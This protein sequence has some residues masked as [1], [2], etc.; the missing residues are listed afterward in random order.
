M[1]NLTDV[2]EKHLRRAIELSAKARQ[3]G[4]AP[5]GAVLA[6]EQGMSLLEA[7][8]AVHTDRDNTAHAETALVRLATIR[9]DHNFLSRCTLYAS[10]EPCAMCAGAIHWG[11]IGRLVYAMPESRLNDM[12][13]AAGAEF[14]LN[15]SCREVFERSTSPIQIIG[16]T[17]EDEAAAV[18]EGYF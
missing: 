9:Y 2:D 12:K 16:P 10:T 4:N 8:N 7:E 1:D 3:K 17:L 6:S 11:R 13:N 15:L 5:F 18:F 14:Q